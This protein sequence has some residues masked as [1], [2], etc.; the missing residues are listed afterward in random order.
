[1]RRIERCVLLVVFVSPTKCR[2]ALDG[3]DPIVGFRKAGRDVPDIVTL[4][5]PI[6][7]GIRL[8]VS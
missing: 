3:L 4:G 7:T 1:M 2:S 5:K 8:P 6:V